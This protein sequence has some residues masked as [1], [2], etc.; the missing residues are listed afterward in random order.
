M[1][2][3]EFITGLAIAGLAST[4]I[5]SCV[6]QSA[7]KVGKADEDKEF[8]WKMVT[9]WPPNFPIVGEG[10]KLLAEWV[11]QMSRGQMTIHVYGGG[12]LVPALET[13]EAVSIG[14]V[15]LGSSASYYWA[16]KIP[17]AQFFAA[18]PFGFNA[19]QMNTWLDA[20]G[21]LELWRELYAPFN[22]IP[23]NA[24]NTGVQMG[25]WY[26]REINT[27]DDFQGLKMRMPGLGGK[28]LNKIG[29]SPI[30]SPGSEIYTN[31]E[32]GVIDATEWLGPFHDSLMGFPDIAKYYY[33]PGWHECGTTLELIA[34]KDKFESL[35]TH[36]QVILT[37][38]IARLKSWILDQ[39]EAK[40]A[41]ALTR[42]RQ[43]KSIEIRPFSD[44]VITTLRSKTIET[45][46]EL[47]LNDPATNQVY[48][49]FKS[50]SAKISDW[51]TISEAA[52]YAQLLK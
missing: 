47:A 34:N 25:G 33:Y 42:I 26:N 30:L 45:L 51:A 17:A 38:A 12:E 7:V 48:Q 31:L 32:R 39:F 14:G 36:L 15:E 49:S 29:G 19:Q 44:D 5:V 40:N 21:G 18:V 23:F 13:F 4:G 41:E 37:S 28:V 50:F 43:N 9:T 35:P 11:A 8:K 27:I 6:D 2:R 10:C 52:Y 20:G 46:E 16:G 22:L 1:K 3:K 24:G